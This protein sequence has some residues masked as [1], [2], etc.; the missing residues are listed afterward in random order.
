[1]KP[2]NYAPYQAH[3]VVKEYLFQKFYNPNIII[4]IS[5]TSFEQAFELLISITKN[6]T[7][8]MCTNV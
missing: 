6:P 3:E 5:S 2:S 7:D 4:A 1:M 8:F